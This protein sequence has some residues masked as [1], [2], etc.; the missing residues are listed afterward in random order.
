MN[1]L[2]TLLRSSKGMQLPDLAVRIE[3]YVISKLGTRTCVPAL[4]AAHEVNAVSLKKVRSTR[5]DVT[6]RLT[7]FV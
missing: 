1:F 4:V 5:W 3:P 6:N 7:R 2:I